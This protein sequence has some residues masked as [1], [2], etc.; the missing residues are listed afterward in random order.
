MSRRATGAVTAAVAAEKDVDDA[1]A[2]VAQL[3]PDVG[4]RIRELRLARGMSQS[5]LAGGRLTKGFISQVESGRSKPSPESLHFIAGRLGVPMAALMPGVELSQQQAF[6]LRAA[7]AEL[8][9]GHTA[10]AHALLDEAEQ[11]L[12][13]PRDRSWHLRMRGEVRLLQG[14]IDAAVEDGLAAY[15]LISTVD[16]PEEASRASNL[17]GK[18]HHVAGR[19][20]A[21]LL[22][23]DRAA[24]HAEHRP[25]GPVLRAMIHSNRGTTHMRL[26]DLTHALEAFDAA[27]SSAEDAEDLKQ[28]AIAHM[29]LGEAARQRGELPAA[30]GH[31][32]RAVTLLERIELRQLQAQILHNMG[33]AYFDLGDRERSRVHQERALRAARAMNEPFTVAHVLERLA[34]LDVAEGNLQVAGDEVGESV[35]LARELHIPDLLCRALTSAAEVAEAS[36][37]STAADARLAEANTAAEAASPMERR[38]MLLREGTLRR[39]RGDLEGALSCFE[40]AARLTV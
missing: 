13:S 15:E 31:A 22:Y 7:E 21:A 32:E 3:V 17:L 36:G 11:L 27:R 26:G 23:F 1:A 4:E 18:A 10:A 24:A 37:D 9:S 33:D 14:E 20:P 28:L 16:A 2:E 34:V 38:R 35:N 12:T 6:L 5:D 40:G 19:L 39:A 30:I 29:G 25:V 8:S